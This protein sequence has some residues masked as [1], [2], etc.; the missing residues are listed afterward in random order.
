M[1]FYRSSPTEVKGNKIQQSIIVH[2][3]REYT[4]LTDWCVVSLPLSPQAEVLAMF[5]CNSKIFAMN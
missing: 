5:H 1:F 4:S 2:P 3:Q